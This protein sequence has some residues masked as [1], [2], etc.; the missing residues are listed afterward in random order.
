MLQRFYLKLKPKQKRNENMQ[1]HQKV[2]LFSTTGS[3]FISIEAG[4]RSRGGAVSTPTPIPTPT[5]GY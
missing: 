2:L 1:N 3:G 4:F 5:P